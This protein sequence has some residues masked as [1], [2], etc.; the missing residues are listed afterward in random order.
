[1]PTSVHYDALYQFPSF[2]QSLHDV[3]GPRT[4]LRPRLHVELTKMLTGN[5]TLDRSL[6]VDGLTPLFL[7][8][9]SDELAI[10]D[11]PVLSDSERRGALLFA[12]HRDEALDWARDYEGT[13][14]REIARAEERGLPINE[15][16][17]QRPPRALQY[18]GAVGKTKARQLGVPE[19]L[20]DVLLESEFP[21]DATSLGIDQAIL[22]RVNSWYIA[23]KTTAPQAVPVPGIGSHTPVRLTLET[24]VAQLR[25]PLSHY[26]LQ[27]TEEQ[28]TLAR[29]PIGRGPY[30]IKGAAGTGKTLVGLLRMRHVVEQM[31]LFEQRPLLYTCYNQVLS[32]TATQLLKS[33]MAGHPHAGLV[34]VRTI[35]SL[36]QEWLRRVDPHWRFQ[37]DDRALARI[38]ADVRARM[39]DAPLPDWTDGELL[40]EL[41]EVIYA[42]GLPNRAAYLAADRSAQGR[43]RSLTTEQRR[44]VWSLY[45]RFRTA[46]HERG[47]TPWAQVAARLDQAL[48]REPLTEATYS[49]VIIDEFQDFTPA[50]MSVITRLQAGGQENL[51]LLG[52]PT[53]TVNQR[54]FRWKDFGIHYK[55]RNSATLSRVFR[56]SRAIISAALPLGRDQ[57]EALGGDLLLPNVPDDQRPPVEVWLCRNEDVELAAIAERIDALV[58][59]GMPPSNVA[60]LIEGFGRQRQLESLL[61]ARSIRIER[62]VKANGRKSL[63]IFDPSVKVLAPSSAKGLEF[64]VVFVPGITER[65]YPTAPVPGVDLAHRR[66]QLYV[67][68][69]RAGYSLVLP[70]HSPGESGLLRELD[71]QFVR[72]RH[73]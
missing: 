58:Q 63:D 42:R 14:Q 10:I 22:D 13:P 31:D 54:G 28:A 41:F 6:V 65:R 55:S 1:V 48:A 16:P 9:I 47:L 5:G 25:I 18:R 43:D 32:N 35:H 57:H 12:A 52:D 71:Q 30:V 51:M 20:I 53:Q 17:D 11:S 34:Q 68:M 2:F 8:G 61:Q 44:A 23:Q 29:Q 7:T 37:S 26:L 38:M 27:L 15:A 40:E 33:V 24:L 3:V 45:F 46:S 56:S 4:D 39:G 70:S 67:S 36:M 64:Q 19:P 66:R 60:V 72:V 62:H 59:V 21:G 73:I 69:T 49:G 50:M